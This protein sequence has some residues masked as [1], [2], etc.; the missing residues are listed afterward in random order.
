MRITLEIIAGP[1]LGR[2]FWLNENQSLVVGR[3]QHADF[4]LA[5]DPQLSGRHFEVQW[6]DG[7]F[8]LRDLQSTNGTWV[9]GL[10]VEEVC[11]REGDL[12]TAGRTQFRTH[13][14]GS[15]SATPPIPLAGAKPGEP[16]NPSPHVDSRAQVSPAESEPVAAP[17]AASGEDTFDGPILAIDNRTRFAVAAL[18][19]WNA[20]GAGRLTVIVKATF[21]FSPSE[22]SIAERQRSILFADQHEGDD[23]LQPAREEADTAPF[24]PR[25]DVVLIGNAYTPGGRPR[26]SLDVRLRVGGLQRRLRV[27]GDR[28]WLFPTRLA[29]VPQISDAVPFT[30]MPLTY[31]RAFGGIDEPAGRYCRENLAGVGYIGEPT[32]ASIHQKPL[33]NWE[34]PEQLIVGWETQ[35]SPA[36]CGF[37]GRGWEPRIKFAGTYD[38]AH[39]RTRAPLPPLDFSYEF[40][41]GAHP[42]LQ[43]AGYLAGDE[44]VELE[45]F[46]R[47]GLAKFS[48][49]GVRPQITIARRGTRG[50]ENPVRPPLDT[51]VFLPDE[52]VFYEV[53]RAV[54]PLQDLDDPDIATILVT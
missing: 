48:L 6:Q 52:G 16:P 30:E 23:P 8:R 53:F 54:F 32:P 12:V 28:H 35:P 11:L 24:K 19:W 13:L 29:V 50:A 5:H 42:Q 37:Y 21:Q 3:T 22:T 45:G 31:R 17:G 10:R 1:E 46:T 4:T 7:A 43:V 27:F 39:L 47:G 26:T 2:K 18:P 36:G 40:H 34:D 44:L 49:P 41:N 9:N 33:P 20:D 51:L 15:P 14:E 38:D 25:A